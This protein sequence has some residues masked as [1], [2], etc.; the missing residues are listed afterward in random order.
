MCPCTF[1]TDETG[2]WRT[3]GLVHLRLNQDRLGLSCAKTKRIGQCEG[4]NNDG[5]KLTLTNEIEESISFFFWKLTRTFASRLCN[6]CMSG[7][8]NS[9]SG[10]A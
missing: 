5:R 4:A 9:N 6:L 2:W 7:I 3:P 1:G 8:W 10:W